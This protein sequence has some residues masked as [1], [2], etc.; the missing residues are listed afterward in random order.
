V[1]FTQTSVLE[2]AHVL[3]V[4]IVGYSMLPSEAQRKAIFALQHNLAANPTY[5]RYEGNDNLIV[6][7]TGDGA[8]LVFFRDVEAPARCALELAVQLRESGL[9]VRMGIHTGPVYRIADINANRNV[10]GGGINV[11]QRVM[12]VGDA[13]HILVSKAV[14]DVLFELSAW[15]PRLHDLGPTAVKHGL[16]LHLYNLYTDQAGNPAVPARF[17]SPPSQAPS[18]SLTPQPASTTPPRIHPGFG[19]NPATSEPVPPPT[20]AP[21]VQLR[22][23]RIVEQIGSGGMGA[24]FAADD[25]RLDRRVA[26]KFLHASQSGSAQASERFQR[27]ARAASALNHPHICTVYD[28]GNIDGLEYIA[29]ELLEG[30][31]LKDLIAENRSTLEERVRWAAQIA[32]ALETAHARNIIHRDLKPG[33]IFITTRGDVKVLDF[34]LAKLAGPGAGATHGGPTAALWGSTDVTAPGVPL[35]TVAY[36][37][38]EQARGKPVDRRS[39]IFS[40][41]L[42]LY[43]LFAGRMPFPSATSAVLFD[44]ILNQQPAPIREANPQVPAPLEEI[45]FHALE[46]D[47]ANRYQTVAEMR[48]DLESVAAAEFATGSRASV[49]R[50]SASQ[51]HLSSQRRPAAKSAT[52]LRLWQWAVAALLLLLAV[53]A[54]GLLFGG[55]RGGRSSTRPIK[56]LPRQLTFAGVDTAVEASGISPDGKYVA[57]GDPTG[58][59]L[60]LIATGETRKL[61]DTAYTAAVCW[62]PDTSRVIIAEGGAEVNSTSV[63]VVSTT[64]GAKRKLIDHAFVAQGCASPDNS[65]V[66]VIRTDLVQV[67]TIG[68]NGEEPARVLDGP[69]GREILMVTLSPDGKWIAAMIDE[70]G[71][72]PLIEVCT[73]AGQN[74]TKIV[75]DRDLIG[76]GGPANMAWDHHGNLLYAKEEPPP[77]QYNSRLWI[78]PIDLSGHPGDVSEFLSLTGQF[79]ADLS[80]TLDDKQFA[81]TA[82]HLTAKLRRAQIEGGKLTGERPLSGEEAY[83]APWAWT[84]DGQSILSFSTRPDGRELLRRDLATGNTQS[85]ATGSL[86]GAAAITGDGVWAIY[87]AGAQR[88]DEQASRIMRVP[89]KG[90][91]AEPILDHIRPVGVTCAAVP[92]C[93]FA[94]I[95]G[96]DMVISELDP[97][98]GRGPELLRTRASLFANFD[99]SRDGQ[100]ILYGHAE[101]DQHLTLYD[102]RTHKSSDIHIEKYGN[103]NDM[104]YAPDG[105]SLYMSFWAPGAALVKV[106]LDGRAQLLRETPLGVTGY[107]VSPDGR[108]IVFGETQGEAN[109]WLTDRE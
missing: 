34:G 69:A 45:V 70:G 19:A 101:R 104:G 75:E 7:P 105:H 16:I 54:S 39:D 58:F 22:H 14:A 23:Y 88:T 12:D 72:P 86:R 84:P 57:Y 30:R 1:D 28:V 91:L 4:D 32:D 102:L 76:P 13:G 35:G 77:N 48:A 61:A 31:T 92:R 90:G 55:F 46:K 26:L 17:V 93:I 49:R 33:N 71:K 98:K 43:E 9:P 52:Q 3:F 59:Y 64:T 42:V 94:E 108:Q 103:M 53:T 95:Q 68:I 78:V 107:A 15:T 51:M 85:L 82:W 87:A 100:Q 2:I 79:P 80:F 47:P 89:V 73:A 83:E 20:P 21:G 106:G 36:M 65:R 62:T 25:T 8:A 37:S 74:C 6:L 38:P 97:L 96:D 40:F 99:I 27:E 63:F 56:S 29:M 24:V 50:L 81:Y 11:A 44:G 67:W 109:V 41:G 66:T 5:K 60:R 18:I 10:S